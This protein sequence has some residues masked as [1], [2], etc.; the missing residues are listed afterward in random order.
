MLLFDAVAR[1]A[2]LNQSNIL[3]DLLVSC[4]AVAMVLGG[5]I[6]RAWLPVIPLADG[7]T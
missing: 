6:V 2:R 7:D 1:A 3:F 4:A 5:L